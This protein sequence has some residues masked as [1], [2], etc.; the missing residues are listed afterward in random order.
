M[1]NTF[2]NLLKARIS[3]DEKDIV[4]ILVDV[5]LILEN[6]NVSHKEKYE[7]INWLRELVSSFSKQE[8]GTLYWALGKFNDDSSVSFLRDLSHIVKDSADPE[9]GWQFL[10]A[11]ENIIGN[12]VSFNDADVFLELNNMASKDQRI[13]DALSRFSFE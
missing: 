4:N 9:V 2:L 12:R 5:A 7:I 8:I 11:Y 6:Q 13:S 10:I 3:S 1:V